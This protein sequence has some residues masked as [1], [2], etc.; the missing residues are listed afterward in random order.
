MCLSPLASEDTTALVTCGHVL[1][2]ACWAKLKQVCKPVCPQC[3]AVPKLELRLFLNSRDDDASAACETDDGEIVASEA[4]ACAPSSSAAGATQGMDA[5]RKKAKD[6]KALLVARERRIHELQQA[7][8]AAEDAAT[9]VR[10][11]CSRTVAAASREAEDAAKQ[12]RRWLLTAAG[13]AP[14]Q[15]QC[16]TPT[17]PRTSTELIVPL[18]LWPTHALSPRCRLGAARRPCWRRSGW[19]SASAAR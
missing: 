10:D 2:S 11:T 16:G 12:V 5:L 1:H 17:S 18:C 19:R 3:R 4:E 9:S 7:V 15:P 13:V 8:V 14:T 6:R